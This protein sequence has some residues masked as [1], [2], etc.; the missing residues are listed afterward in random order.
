MSEKIYISESSLGRG[1]FAKVPIEPR[2]TV[3]YL[4]GKVIGFDEAVAL[5]HEAYT[6]QIGRDRYIDPYSPAKF[7]NHSC[8]PNSGFVDEIRLVATRQILPGEEIRFDYS[9]T[10]LERSWEM[11]CRCGAARCRSRVRDFDLLP[12]ALQVRYLQLGI[13]QNFIVEE[14]ASVRRLA[15]RVA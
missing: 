4:T 10:M 2:E 9:T 11:D 14:I 8:D 13:V 5:P 12:T 7:L 6:I 1:V 3:F 15:D